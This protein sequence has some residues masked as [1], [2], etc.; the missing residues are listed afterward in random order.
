MLLPTPTTRDFKDGQAAH[1]RDGVIQT[2]TLARVLINGAER[3]R[4][5]ES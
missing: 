2:D 4:E 3:E 5:R 1:R